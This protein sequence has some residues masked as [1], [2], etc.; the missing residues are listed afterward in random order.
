MTAPAHVFLTRFNL[1]STGV[2]SIIR[3][4]ETWLVQRIALFER[5][6][7][8]SVRSQRG[9]DI[10]WIVYLDPQSPEWLLRRM[11]ELEDEGLLLAIRREAVSPE[12]LA[13]D[14]RRAAGRDVGSVITANLDNDDGLAIDFVERLRLA[15]VTGQRTAIYLTR[16]LIRSGDALYLREDPDNAF[17]A[18][19]EDLV[20]PLT[21]WADWHNRLDQHMP[22][23]R[24]SG[25]PVWLQVVHGA[26]VS[27]RVRGRLT[28]PAA[29]TA[30]FPGLLEGVAEPT[31]AAVLRDRWLTGPVR[32]L[33][34]GARAHARQGLVRVLGKDGYGSLRYALTSRRAAP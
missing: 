32:H 4:A 13:A 15:P 21:C 8:P 31:R 5:Y 10:H 19:R 30:L 25:P 24:L 12:D 9:D 20:D 17:C 33:R 34:D 28:G 14:V 26:N 6:T 23:A 29:H 7:V 27:N 16:G 1:P 22:V 2:E 18:V 3:A 11:G